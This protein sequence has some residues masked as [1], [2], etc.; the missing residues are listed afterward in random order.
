LFFL[1]ASGWFWASRWKMARVRV[2]KVI[3]KIGR[4][5]MLDVFALAILV[6]L[7]K[8]QRLATVVP[9]KGLFAFSAV[10]VFTLCAS[11]SFEPQEIWR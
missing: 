5:A 1:V 4:W 10:I 8:L 3:D 9:G 6:S 11:A 2:Y 7:V